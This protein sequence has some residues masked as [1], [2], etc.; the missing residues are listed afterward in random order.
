[1]NKIELCTASFTFTQENDSCDSGNLG[2]AL[3]VVID[4]A[5]GG[6]FFV[7]KTERWATD[8]QE[9][10]AQLLATVRTKLGDWW[11]D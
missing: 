5:G 6:H 7:L 4:D 9:E 11:K 2:Q 1:M 8:D 10:V 3:E